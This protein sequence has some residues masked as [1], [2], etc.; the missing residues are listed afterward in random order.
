MANQGR[1]LWEMLTAYF[2]NPVEMQVD[3][4]LRAK[5]GSGVMINDLDWQEY[6][7]FLREIREYK[8]SVGPKEFVFADYVLAAKPLNQPEVT[9]RLRINPRAKKAPRETDLPHTV[10]LLTHADDLA[11]SEELHNVVKDTTKKFQVIENDQVTEEY[12]R[13]HDVLGSY[14]ARVAVIRDTDADGEAELNEVERLRIEYWD[15]W[16]E[17]RDIAGQPFT[18]YLFVEMNQADGWF[19]LWRGREIDPQQVFVF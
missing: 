2:A 13:I 7:F 14:T 11:Y 8:R 5:I 4:P 17:A 18:Q 3:N 16:R 15:Y 10:L 9:V 1:T 12:H 6:N 19:Q